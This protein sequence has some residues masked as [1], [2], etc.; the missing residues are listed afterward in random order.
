MSDKRI[1]SHYC[2][3]I[4]GDEFFFTYSLDNLSSPSHMGFNYPICIA[5]HIEDFSEC[6]FRIPKYDGEL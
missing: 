1:K 3:D 2:F 5:G 4:W 6:D